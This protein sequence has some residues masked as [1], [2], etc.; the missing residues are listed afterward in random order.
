M[1]EI[2]RV[3]LTPHQTEPSCH[4][5]GM[6][7]L[8]VATCAVADAVAQRRRLD[9]C[10]GGLA[11]QDVRQDRDGNEDRGTAHRD[12]AEQR[13]EGEADEEIERDPRQVEQG[14]RAAACE[15][16]ADLVEIAQRLLSIAFG[17]AAQGR[18]D[19]AAE[20]A[21]A[22]VLVDRGTDAGE[23]AAAEHVE[24]ALEEEQGEDDG[25]EA[26]SVGMLRL[27]RTRS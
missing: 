19:L 15:K 25:R 2:L 7:D 13:M 17:L 6:H 24:Q 9:R 1:A 10:L 8:G 23:D 3:G 5:H 21:L 22:Q 27:G 18:R 16:G 11:G 14:R 4:A 26:D 12:P 20:D